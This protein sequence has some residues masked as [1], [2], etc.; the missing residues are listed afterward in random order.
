MTAGVLS[1]RLLHFDRGGMRSSDTYLTWPNFGSTAATNYN[2]IL[3]GFIMRGAAAGSL[4]WSALQPDGEAG[5]ATSTGVTGLTRSGAGWALDRWKGG[6]VM[7]PSGS[8]M[9][10]TGNGSGKLNGTWVGGVPPGTTPYVVGGPLVGTDINA[11]FDNVDL[12]NS[13][14]PTYPWTL[15]NRSFSGESAPAW[16]LALGTGAPSGIANG[17]TPIAHTTAWWD[18]T[19]L[20]GWEVFQLTMAAY[21]P[22]YSVRSSISSGGLPAGVTNTHTMNGHP[23]LGGVSEMCCMT[24]FAEPLMKDDY[25][26]NTDTGPPT[27]GQ[28]RLNAIAAGYTF[29]HNPANLGTD[30]IQQQAAMAFMPIAWP[31]TPWEFSFNPAQDLTTVNTGTDETWTE[32]LMDY[33]VQLSGTACP[34]VVLMNNS[35]RANAANGPASWGLSAP[36]SPYSDRSS[37]YTSMYLALLAYSGGPGI[38]DLVGTSQAV[39]LQPQRTPLGIQTST[40]SGMGSSA[41]ALKNT[42]TY[43]G[44]LGARMIELPGDGATNFHVLTANDPFWA[45]SIATMLAN[46]R[47]CTVEGRRYAYAPD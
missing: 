15:G 40:Y 34:R 22:V 42:L 19:Y 33:A 44:K 41:A 17:T 21:V 23:L 37:G 39:L 35:L 36:V 25:N 12:Y 10:I 20:M 14:A 45:T 5:T 32:T 47:A 8:Y 18:T 11:A 2:P 27:A 28:G 46:D 7:T 24:K 3:G 16:A 13:T 1:K 38:A 6:F 4:L 30:N 43:A 29:N 9:S 26:D 31:D